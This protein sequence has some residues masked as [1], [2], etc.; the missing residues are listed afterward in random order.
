MPHDAF[1]PGTPC[2]GWFSPL[3]CAFHQHPSVAGRH[4]AVLSLCIP[5]ASPVP[6]WPMYEGQGRSL[7]PILSSILQPGG[8]RELMRDASLGLHVLLPAKKLSPKRSPP[9]ATTCASAKDAPT[10]TVRGENPAQIWCFSC[11]GNLLILVGVVRG[12]QRLRKTTWRNA[13]TW[14]TKIV[15]RQGAWLAQEME[16][17]WEVFCSAPLEATASQSQRG[18]WWQVTMAPNQPWLLSCGRA[19]APRWGPCTE[20]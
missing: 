7:P 3:C 15:T 2:R 10:S 19:E 13:G 1:P 12:A 6:P 14:D 18:F 8:D 5:H 4:K 20:E 11:H 17:V 9:Q 16:Q